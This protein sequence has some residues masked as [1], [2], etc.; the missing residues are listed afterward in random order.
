[1]SQTVSRF[2]DQLSCHVRPLPLISL[3]ILYF[4]FLSPKKSIK[5]YTKH[6]THPILANAMGILKQPE[7]QPTYCRTKLMGYFYER[8]E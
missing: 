1:M 2:F 4:H 6:E 5:F 3:G 8:T 7:R